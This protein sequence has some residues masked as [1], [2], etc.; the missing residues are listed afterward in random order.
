[1]VDD[2]ERLEHDFQRTANVLDHFLL[3]INSIQW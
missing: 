2:W 1:M 3:Q